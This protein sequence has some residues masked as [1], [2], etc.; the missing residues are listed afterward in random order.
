MNIIEIKDVSVNYGSVKALDR[1]SISIKKGDFIGVI[2]PNGGGK[3]TLIKVLLGLIKPATGEVHIH[4]DKPIGYVP[5]FNNFEKKF[6]ITVCK[7]ILMGSMSDKKNIFHKYTKEDKEKSLKVMTLLGI[8]NLSERLI[9]QLSGGQM[10]K[11]LIARALMTDPDILILDEPTA[12][13][14]SQSRT[15][16]YNLFNDLKGKKTIILISHDIGSI[17]SY[18]DSIACLNVQLY[19]HENG[20][21]TEETISKAYGCPVD[22]IAHGIPHR[23]LP[24]HLKGG[25]N[26]D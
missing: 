8:E 20:N 14:D 11:V 25:H 26:H 22:I 21:L 1:V 15:D 23:V 10:Q 3:T 2:G 4:S 24:E 16:I 7:V 9:S 13:I 12:S 18:I 19:Y 5:Q 17:S 6:P